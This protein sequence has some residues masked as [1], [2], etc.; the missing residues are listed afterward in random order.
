MQ[1]IR[2]SVRSIKVNI[3]FSCINV[4]LIL[5]DGL[6]GEICYI[7]KNVEGDSET[8]KESSPLDTILSQFNPN[9]LS[10]LYS[11]CILHC[12]SA[13]AAVFK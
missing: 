10:L 3:I 8:L 7:I 4:N 12:I 11:I 2:R 6:Y 1:D 5:Y 13:S 9:T